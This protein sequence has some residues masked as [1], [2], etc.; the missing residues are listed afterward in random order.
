MIVLKK[1]GLSTEEAATTCFFMV[2]WQRLNDSCIAVYFKKKNSKHQYRN[3]LLSL[4]PLGLLLRTSTGEVGIGWKSDKDQNGARPLLTGQRITEQQDGNYN[5]E[6]FSR[7]CHDW[8][9]QWSKGGHNWKDKVL[10]KSGTE[11]KGSEPL[12]T[13]RM[14]LN[15]GNEFLKFIGL[16]CC[17][18]NLPRSDPL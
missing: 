8:A 10:S 9:P 4:F 13:R 1:K 5:C 17:L 2:L 11:A 18:S 14:A 7:R 3:K 15:E 12:D 16:D 6:K